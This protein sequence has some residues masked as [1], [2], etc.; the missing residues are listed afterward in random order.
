RDQ[1]DAQADAAYDRL[2]TFEADPNLAERMPTAPAGSAASK[3]IL[4]KMAEG[5][6]ADRPPNPAEL[7]ELHRMIAELQAQPFVQRSFNETIRRGGD[8]EV[9]PGSAGAPVYHDILQA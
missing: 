9:N 1:L 5:L 7:R 3:A 4:Q 2:R 6:G 8:L